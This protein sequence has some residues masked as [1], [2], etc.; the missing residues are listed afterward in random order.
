MATQPILPLGIKLRLNDRSLSTTMMALAAIFMVCGAVIL[1]LTRPTLGL[2]NLAWMLGGWTL[3]WGT[4][5]WALRRKLNDYDMFLIP[6]TALLTGWGLL[7]QA[8]LAPTMLPRQVAWIIIGCLMLY[9]VATESRLLRWLRRYRYT[10]LT[11][12]LIF[13]GATLVFGVNPSGY[14]QRL[15]L[16]FGPI[17]VQPSE[18]LKL[19][20][21]IYLAAYLSEHRLLPKADKRI[22]RT[23]LAVLGPMAVMVGLA[24]LLVGWQQDLGAAL[25]FYL[26]FVAMI[27]LAWGNGWY[28]FISLMLF[29][30]VAVLGY[31]FSDR[32]ALRVDIW[33]APWTPERADQTF[34][35]RQS[36]FALSAGGLVGQGLGLGLPSVI[37]AVHTDFVYAALVEEFGLLG[38][39]AA[40]GLIAAFIFRGFSIAQGADSVFETLLAGGIGA[41]VG[42]QAWVI[43]GGNACLIPI[44]GVTFPFLSYGG[45]SLVVLMMATGILLNISSPHAKPLELTISEQKPGPE[46]A[47]A[48]LGVLMIALLSSIALVTGRWTVLEA[49]KLR[50]TVTNPRLVIAESRIRRGRILDRR[51]EE[52][53]GI[54][55]DEEGLV[56]RTYPVPEAAPVVGY[57]TFAYGNAGIEEACDARLRGTAGLTEW[58]HIWQQ[59]LHETPSGEDVKL[60]LD[61]TLQR[62]AQERLRGHVGAAV[63]IDAYTGDVLALA[64]SPTYDPSAVAPQWDDLRN[65]PDAP[66]LNRATQGLFQPGGVLAPFVLG[67]AWERLDPEI[68]PASPITKPVPI[69]DYRLQ[70][71]AQPLGSDWQAIMTAGCPY[72]FLEIGRR[73]G[74]LSLTE[75]LD[76]WGFTSAPAL[77]LPTVNVELEITSLDPELEAIGQGDLLVTPLQLAQA[78]AALSNRGRRPAPHLLTQAVEGCPPLPL[79]EAARPVLSPELAQ[80]LQETFQDHDGMRGYTTTALAGPERELA[81]FL[82]LGPAETWRYAVV[83]LLDQVRPAKPRAAEDI[84]LFLLRTASE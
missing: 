54:S 14:G 24:L 33:L 37:P 60:T 2:A 64:S 76:Q 30:P 75:V 81:W 46:R 26:T 25:L 29:I 28:A 77:A 70:C 80:R 11:F 66:L 10:A 1:H 57:A 68:E 3:A 84:G 74:R 59:L 17:Y 78:T 20:L 49:D 69:N 47:I 39:I 65:A 52:L 32:V 21:V 71:Q 12:G 56:T 67:S 35:L 34:Q 4:T 22:Y 42:I 5:T 58:E 55:V 15:W 23:W 51:G 61:A 8:R 50:A 9:V 38:A 19:L 40:L 6:I 83:V 43:A 72:P 79:P 45:S 63:L 7:L 27:F 44:T 41:L 13:L 48:A 73:L 16:G 31:H 18:L 36:L 53:A 82:G 62:L